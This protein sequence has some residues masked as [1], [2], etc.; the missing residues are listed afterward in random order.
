[1]TRIKHWHTFTLLAGLLAWNGMAAAQ[2]AT[3]PDTAGICT[4]F[5][6]LSPC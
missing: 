6:K 3:M 5:E 4:G 1:M 2:V